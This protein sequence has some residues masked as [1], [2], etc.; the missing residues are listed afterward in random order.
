MSHRALR[1]GLWVALA[2]L[3]ACWAENAP[4]QPG[5][6]PRETVNQRFTTTRPGSPTGLGFSAS[7]HAA[8]DA[9]APPPYMKRVVVYPPRGMRYDTSVPAR[10]TAGDVELQLL[11]PAACPRASR[12]G[13]GTVEGLFQMPFAHDFTFDHF[14]HAV[15]VVNGARQQIIL[16][17]SEGYTVVRGRFRPDGSLAWRLPTCFPAPPAGGCVDDYILQLR[18][19]N[20]LPRYTRTSAGRIRSY[21]T[22]PPS[23]PASGHWRTTVR[24]TWS[25]GTVDHVTS[26]Q[27]CRSP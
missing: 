7:Y 3:F 13:T 24:Y 19:A 6:G 1:I 17:K 11:G 22:T 9:K 26:E 14:K 25:N 20:F 2:A 5:S 21:A 10:C 8:G 18:N 16:I 27:P 15:D 4:A 12:L 23:C